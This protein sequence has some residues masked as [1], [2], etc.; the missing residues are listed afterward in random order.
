M[1]DWVLDTLLQL[2]HRICY[3]WIIFSLIQKVSALCEKRVTYGSLHKICLIKH[4][5]KL[6]EQPRT[7]SISRLGPGCK[8]TFPIQTSSPFS[9]IQFHLQIFIMNLSA[10]MQDKKKL[11]QQQAVIY[12]QQIRKFQEP[13]HIEITASK[14]YNGKNISVTLSVRLW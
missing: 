12:L 1:F 4:G 8:I 10:A 7:M 6:K 3:C 2:S 14:V 9:P 5:N 13:L 11:S